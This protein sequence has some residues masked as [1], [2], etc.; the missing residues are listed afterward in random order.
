VNNASAPYQYNWSNGDTLALADA[1]VAGSYQVTLTDALGCT[2][3]EQGEVQDR[4]SLAL[5]LFP[6]TALVNIVDSIQLQAT[7]VPLD[8]TTQF[9]WSPPDALS[10]TDCLMPFASP[11][12]DTWFVFTATSAY[13][14]TVSDSVLVN[15]WYTCAGD[16]RAEHLFAQQRRAE[17]RTLCDGWL[18]LGIPF[19]RYRP[20][21][22]NGFSN[23]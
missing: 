13:G 7:L 6:D 3:A 18:H 4:G 16:L 1:L 5:E 12:S 2:Y 23:G 9:H 8:S 22:R 19:Q 15:T 14:C 10:C 20:M 21:G 17:R 11:Q